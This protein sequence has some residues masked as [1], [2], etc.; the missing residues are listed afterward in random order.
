MLPCVRINDCGLADYP[1]GGRLGPRVLAD[2]EILWIERGECRWEF[3][4]QVRIC[5]PGS[6]LLCPPGMRDV[7][8]WD[9]EQ[10][11][12]HGFVHFDFLEDPGVELPLSRDCPANDVLR[13]LLRHA[14]SLAGND[15]AET[16]HLAAAALSQALTWYASGRLAPRSEV[17]AIDVHPVVLRALRVLGRYWRD[18]PK[19]PP[20]IDRWA[21]DTGVS[22]GHLSRVCRLELGVT[23]LELLRHLRLDHGLLLLAR[24]D[25]KI[26]DI[27]V[28]CGFKNQ[29]HYSRCCRQA[30]GYS[31][32][33]LRQQML[34]G[35]D[36]PLS[37]VVGLRRLLQLVG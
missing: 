9:A 25:L 8:V 29:F 14:V 33:E 17:A 37:R 18:G 34:A 12:R 11:T 24:T 16:D 19:L 2:Y 28:A 10:T 20:P 31:P 6:V 1:S 30:Y 23:P 7:W 5:R 21:E 4:G 15:S 36:K 22:R 35:G 13:P 32:R 3:G 27:S 26:S